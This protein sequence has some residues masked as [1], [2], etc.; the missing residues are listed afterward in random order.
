[1]NKRSIWLNFWKGSIWNRTILKLSALAQSR[2]ASKF[3]WPMRSQSMTF[4]LL[5]TIK[6][7]FGWMYYSNSDEN[8]TFYYHI[9]CCCGIFY[10][11]EFQSVNYALL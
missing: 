1:M 7:G 5:L 8:Q 2:S 11:V 10:S 4:D 3:E 6:I 9:L